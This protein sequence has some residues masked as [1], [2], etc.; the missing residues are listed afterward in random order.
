L[1]SAYVN[2]AP[3]GEVTVSIPVGN[4]HVG[5]VVEATGAVGI[6]KAALMDAMLLTAEVQLAAFT[7]TNV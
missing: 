3:S 5:C 7:T 2:P 4:G 1:F 6:A